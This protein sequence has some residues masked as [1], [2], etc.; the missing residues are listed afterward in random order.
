MVEVNDERTKMVNPD[1]IEV[2]VEKPA[3]TDFEEFYA[4][5]KKLGLKKE[6]VD[7]ALLIGKKPRSMLGARQILMHE[8]DFIRAYEFMASYQFG[9]GN[10]NGAYDAMLGL[11]NTIASI[12]AYSPVFKLD[13]KQVAEVN[14]IREDISFLE[15][16]LRLSRTR[17]LMPW[18]V[19]ALRQFLAMRGY[20]TELETTTI[21][22]LVRRS[23]K[24]RVDGL[25]V[26]VKV[27]LY[28]LASSRR[29]QQTG[30]PG[31]DVDQQSEPSVDVGSLALGAVAGTRPPREAQPEE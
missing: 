13:L 21:L 16:Y 26:K 24:G 5:G 20:D 3:D 11:V 2:V 10:L 1:P 6:T 29:N 31:K 18:D 8:Q 27:A 12:S 30:E 15:E 17:Y 7:L 14:H 23:Y 19:R 25:M 28:P 22:D 9:R 4:I